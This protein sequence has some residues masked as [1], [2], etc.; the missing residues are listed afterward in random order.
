MKNTLFTT[1]GSMGLIDFISF[2]GS[3]EEIN[4]S[5]TIILNIIIAT[6]A[7]IKLYKHKIKCTKKKKQNY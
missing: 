2:S 3:M 7:L 1:I 6:T 5:L 4:T